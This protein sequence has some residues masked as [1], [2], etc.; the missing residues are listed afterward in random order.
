MFAIN[1]KWKTENNRLN[2]MLVMPP[3]KHVDIDFRASEI[4]TQ[5]VKK[6]KSF[7]WRET[8]RCRSIHF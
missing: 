4:S 2:L 8:R 7:R 1:S 6:H 5:F 3:V